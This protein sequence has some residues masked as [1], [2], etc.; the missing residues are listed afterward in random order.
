[1]WP[2]SYGEEPLRARVER[3]SYPR[4]IRD[5]AVARFRRRGQAGARHLPRPAGD[6]RRVRR[7][8]VSGH[9]DPAAQARIAHR[10]AKL[11]DQNFH[12][13]EFVPGT[14]L[15]DLYPHPGFK[16]PDRPHRPLRGQQRASPGHHANWHRTSVVEARC[17]NDG[18]IE[19][20]RYDTR[21]A[22][23][24]RTWRQCS[25]IRNFTTGPIHRSAV[26]RP[27]AH[28]L[29]RRCAQRS[30]RHH[31]DMLTVIESRERPRHCRTAPK[32]RPSAVASA[33][34]RRAPRS[35]LGRAAA[36]RTPRGDSTLP[37]RT[38]AR[39]SSDSLRS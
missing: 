36:D 14:R 31:L 5:R 9:P 2:G 11:Y 24:S 15:A 34:P 26:R 8:A 12:T 13:I 32:T 35:P 30:T 19:A 21:A 18:V 4:R 1:M 27:V 7:H 38:G 22:R 37:R 6:Q 20:I 23:S 25:G 39:D 28:R 3:R 29:P 33:I 17:P 10:D 16:A